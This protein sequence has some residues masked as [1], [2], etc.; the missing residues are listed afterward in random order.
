MGG[1]AAKSSARYCV[2]LFVSALVL[3]MLE[4]S[5]GAESE[6]LRIAVAR[7]SHETCTFCP[8]TT[9][10][11]DWE[12][13][14]PPTRELF[15]FKGSYIGGFKRMCD[16]FGG[17]ELAGVLSPRGVAGGSS[18]SWNTR[19]A[20]DK[21]AGLIVNDIIEQGPFDGVFLSL[22][23]AMAVTDV[24]KPEAELVRRVRRA[25]EDIPIVVTL[26]SNELS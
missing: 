16:E 26:N 24:P 11:A 9:T 5:Y 1:F 17:V 18:K 7:F 13:S 15:E 8:G 4:A 6:T 14:G 2:R 21:Y 19:R 12:R 22:H 10:V 3:T 23:G 20:F 25:V